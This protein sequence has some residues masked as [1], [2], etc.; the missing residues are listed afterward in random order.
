MKKYHSDYTY[1]ECMEEAKKH[2]T[3]TTFYKANPSMC[4]KARRLGWLKD[5]TWMT[6][7]TSN[8]RYTYE[9]CYQEA[10]TCKSRKELR[11]KSPYVYNKARKSGWL[12]DYTWFD[13][14]DE[15]KGHI[16]TVY[17]YQDEDTN[18]MY[19]GL[20]KNLDKRHKQHCQPS[21]NDAVY[22]YFKSI[23]KEVQQ[24]IILKD[25]LYQADGKYFEKYYINYYKRLGKNMLNSGNAGNVG[26]VSVWTREKCYEEAKKYTS[27]RDFYKHNPA[28]YIHA[29]E[30]GWVEDYTWFEC[31]KLPKYFWNYDN[32]MEE[33]RKYETFYE[34]RVKNQTAYD[35]ARNNGWLN[36][37]T[38]LR[39]LTKEEKRGRTNRSYKTLEDG[40]TIAGKYKSIKEF[41]ENDFKGYSVIRGKPYY[42]ELKEKLLWGVV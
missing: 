15:A 29:K 37:Y 26:S 8:L 4:D 11:R 19:V 6:H 42:K 21:V 16:Y 33:A 13:Q 9:M 28:A 41:R 39:D 1:D 7:V 10:L 31:L 24:P 18:T 25:H 2:V 23:G 17:A 14:I 3:T 36:D 35:I 38:W 12:N 22:Q 32:T 40:L 5:Y 27:K 30:N 20:T 34:F